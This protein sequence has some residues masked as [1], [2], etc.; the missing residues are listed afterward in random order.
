MEKYIKDFE[1]S[2]AP[3]FKGKSKEKRREMAIA[4]KLQSK[5]TK[6]QEAS[7]SDEAYALHRMTDCGQDAAQT[8]IDS[9][10][11]V[12]I[13]KLLRDLIA[14]KAYRYIVRDV[15]KGDVDPIYK[16]QFAKKYGTLAENNTLMGDYGRIIK[17]LHLASDQ[18]TFD[19]LVTLAKKTSMLS[20]NDVLDDLRKYRTSIKQ[21]DLG[22]EVNPKTTPAQNTA[23]Q[24]S[25]RANQELKALQKQRQQVMFD[26]EQEA[27]P[28]GGPIARRY[29]KELEKIDKAISRLTSKENM[30]EAT[31]E[32]ETEFHTKLDAL[33]HKTFGKRKEELKER[34]ENEIVREVDPEHYLVTKDVEEWDDADMREYK[35]IWQK[36]AGGA[37][38]VDMLKKSVM[39]K[40]KENVGSAVMSKDTNPVD[41]KKLT[42][43]GINVQLKEYYD[44]FEDT[45]DDDNYVDVSGQSVEMAM[46]ELLMEYEERLKGIPEESRQKGLKAIKLY[47]INMIKDWNPDLTTP[48]RAP[49]SEAKHPILE[50]REYDYE[51]QMAKSQLISIVKNAKS[52]F[53]TIGDK[54]QLQSWVQ[55]K[56]TKAEDYLNAVA[57]YIEGESI[58]NTAPLMVNNEPA[59]DDEGTVLN[60]GDVVR[61]ADGGIYQAIHSYSEGR[62]FLTP[63]DLKKRKT[64]NLK[65]RHYFDNISEDGMS[66]TK[67]M[68]KV[69]AHNQTKGGFVK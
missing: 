20:K 26:M 36:R 49:I 29:G 1:K 53:D 8:F 56:L 9:N 69:M 6:L 63:F 21:G 41:V 42:D 67:K 64:T 2:D 7:V 10:P 3:Q 27:E 54:T 45:L 40:V 19:E 14:D 22:I 28:E 11:N 58:S 59:R 60:I 51:G 34:R 31:K 25:P 35:K 24:L 12:D 68:Y 57:R 17:Q 15:V 61:A 33:V 66:I 18:N 55:S 4:A 30:K 37:Q 16:K 13:K 62:P 23:T 5:G 44:F 48:H 65:E 47:W 50:V 43:K 32:E 39:T 46:E 52:L 38:F